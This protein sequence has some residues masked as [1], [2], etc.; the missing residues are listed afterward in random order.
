MP[1]KA[2]KAT[3]HHSLVSEHFLGSFPLFVNRWKEGFD[4]REHDHEYLEI[5]YVMTGEGYHYIGNSVERTS[6][7]CLYILPVGTS[8][9]MRPSDSSGKN[10]L[11]VYNLCIRPEFIDLL[12]NWLMQ[13][14]TSSELLSIFSGKPGSHFAVKDK[15]VQF[16]GAFER[17]HQEFEEM[18][19]GYEA[20]M[21]SIL[22]ELTVGINR[23]LEQKTFNGG[24]TKLSGQ[25]RAEMSAILDFVNNHITEP[26]TLERLAADTGISNRHLIRL[27]QQLTG[28]GFSD[29]LQYKR[30]KL[31]CH[32]LIETDLRIENISRNIGYR[33]LTHFRQVFR[34][35]TGT[36]PN[37]Y[38]RSE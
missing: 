22:L 30:I 13:L 11:I 6:T 3:V 38:R 25:R 5:I 8:H 2:A 14:G 31:A 28:M 1:K 24:G 12:R 32:L 17:L 27:F 7:G 15:A 4:L 35:I 36:S 33:S 16:G 29:Y 19:P 37:N 20:S 21:F 9:I 18:K 10:R 34:K 23:L 26:L